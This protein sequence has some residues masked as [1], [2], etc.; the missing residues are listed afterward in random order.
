MGATLCASRREDKTPRVESY[1]EDERR[2]WI[3]RYY[4]PADVVAHCG[5]NDYAD[6]VALL[7]LS[8]LL[9]LLLLLSSLLLLLLL[10]QF[11]VV[12]VIMLLMS[13]SWTSLSLSM[14]LL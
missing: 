4:F 3:Y 13:L 14:L 8:L 6:V 12:G 11:M 10:L 1:T 9:L 2:L 5:D 7:L